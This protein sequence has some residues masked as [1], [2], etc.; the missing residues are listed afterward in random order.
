M[1]GFEYQILPWRRND[2]GTAALAQ[3]NAL[4]AEGWEAVG[5]APRGV[6]VPMS[7]MGAEA[8]PEMV[9]LLKRRLPPA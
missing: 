7:G 1:D 9:V 2:D 5:L 3:L 8:V 6:D 4:G